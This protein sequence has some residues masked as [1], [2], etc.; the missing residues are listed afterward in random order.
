[1]K[2]EKLKRIDL[3]AAS[4]RLIKIRVGPSGDVYLSK[5]TFDVMEQPEYLEVFYSVDD[6]AIALKVVEEATPDAYKVHLKYRNDLINTIHIG[7]Q[8]LVRHMPAGD[9]VYTPDINS[10]DFIFTGKEVQDD[11]SN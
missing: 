2:F 11:S 5:K 4:Q 10:G 3:V 1:M 8:Q 9:Y 7:C 6:I